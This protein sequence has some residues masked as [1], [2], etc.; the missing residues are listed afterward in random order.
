MA[1]APTA[2]N[3]IPNAMSSTIP[4]R[5]NRFSIA[6]PPAFALSMFMFCSKGS[7]CGSY[8]AA[9]S[10]HGKKCLDAEGTG[11]HGRRPDELDF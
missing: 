10:D 8:A 5:T 7:L 3:S 4:V 1:H 9:A 2:A 6:V 11:W